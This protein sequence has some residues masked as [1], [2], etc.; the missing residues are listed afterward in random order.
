LSTVRRIAKNI[1]VLLIG[2][3]ASYTIG[4]FC[5]IYI[6]RSLGPAGFGVLSFAIAFAGIFAVFGDIGLQQLSVREIARDKSLTSKYLANIS[7][8]KIPLA[9]VTF[10][11]IA[12]TINLMG[13]PRDTVIVVYLVG[14]SV[15]LGAFALVYYSIFQALEKMEYQSMGQL[16]SVTVIL[17]GVFIAIKCNFSVIGFASLYLLASIIALIYCLIVIRIKFPTL[18]KV[19]AR[20]LEF[21][22]SFWLQAIRHALPFGLIAFLVG[23]YLGID[24]VILSVV[25][26]NEAV[27]W[28]NAAYKVVLALVFIPSTFFTALF[29]VMSKLYKSSLESLKLV[30]ER[31][32]KYMLILSIPIGV[33]ITVLASRI[34]LQ[35]FG[36]EYEASAIALQILV[37]NTVLIYTNSAF[38]FL[39][40]SIDRQTTVVKV[41]VVTVIANVTLNIILIPA[42]SYVGA[43]IAAVLSNLATLLMLGFILA[44]TEYRLGLN[45]LKNAA[46]ALV[47]CLAMF[48]FIRFA[49]SINLFLLVLIS[50]LIYFSVLYIV[51]GFDKQDVAILKSLFTRE[52]ITT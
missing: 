3:V 13:Y 7:L 30:Y 17:G 24:S 29:P 41:M 6:A 42:Y 44:N 9:I 26:G 48:V 21:D 5:I 8:L 35:V 22:R 20:P 33:G 36:V 14:L 2:Q 50:A 52:S 45:S 46:K 51:K 31:S 23:N 47:S 38:S 32:L 49:S 4:F 34:V 37:W 39:L 18:I 27:G 16:L 28:Y 40:Y 11:L 10:G 43:S 12:L 1:I 25:K 15:M 19:G